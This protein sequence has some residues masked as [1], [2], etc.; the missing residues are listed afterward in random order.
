MKHELCLPSALVEWEWK[1][2]HDGREDP[3]LISR[4]TNNTRPCDRIYFNLVWASSY[5]WD[6]ET[7]LFWKV[8]EKHL[9]EARSSLTPAAENILC[10]TFQ[11]LPLVPV[12]YIA[13]C[14]FLPR[15][16]ILVLFH[17]LGKGHWT[18][19][20]KNTCCWEQREAILCFTFQFCLLCS[21]ILHSPL[22]F[23]TPFIIC[24]YQSR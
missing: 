13:K 5:T 11:N 15:S 7:L 17:I 2:C 16:D 9:F 19:T 14:V 23:P 8:S 6:F 18:L 24:F 4:S 12:K 21:Y 22:C 3:Y 20:R 10:F 1:G